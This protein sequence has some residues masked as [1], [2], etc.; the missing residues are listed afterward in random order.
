M[1]P[2]IRSCV[3]FSGRNRILGVAAKNQMVTNMKNTIHGFK[4]L[5]GRKLNDP[6]VQN[7]AKCLP[8]HIS[9]YNDKAPQAIGIKVNSHCFFSIFIYFK[10][11]KKRS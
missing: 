2:L 6:H 10:E 5:L 8:F 9:S 11:I 4:R 1:F 7:E 3:A